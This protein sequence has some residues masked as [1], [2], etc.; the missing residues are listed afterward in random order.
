M[1]TDL[2]SR[3]VTHLLIEPGPKLAN[4][5]LSKNLADRIWIFRSENLISEDD[6]L[7]AA[8]IHYPNSAETNLHGDTL[9]EYLNP[10]SP[11]FFANTPSADFILA[12]TK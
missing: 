7:P 6:G 9:T 8:T 10:T 5:I 2:Y 12:N 1:L 11:V 3:S 4:F